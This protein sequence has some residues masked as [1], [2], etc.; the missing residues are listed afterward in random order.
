MNRTPN[1]RRA[2][3]F[4]RTAQVQETNAR[5]AAAALALLVLVL[6]IGLPP[7]AG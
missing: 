4:A 3:A 1:R 6:L 5:I 2:I 7:G